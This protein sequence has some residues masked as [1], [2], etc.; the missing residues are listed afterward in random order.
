MSEKIG[1]MEF[2]EAEKTASERD[3]HISEAVKE[4]ISADGEIEISEPCKVIELVRKRPENSHKGTFGKL[5]IIG[6]SERYRGAVQISALAALR[7]G[8]GLVTAI[9]TEGAAQALAVSAKEATV[10]PLP[11]DAK[12]FMTLNDELRD[13]VIEAINSASA[14]LIGPGLGKGSGCVEILKLALKNACCPI[15]L[16]ADGINLVSER[17]EFLRKART[18]PILTPHPAELSRLCGRPLDEILRDR[19]RFAKELAEK[20]RCTVVSKSA[21]TLIFSGDEAC[22]S[23]SGNN[24][25]AKG[26]SGDFL[27]GLIASF[28]AQGYRSFDAARLG[29]TVQGL[30]CEEISEKMSRS[31]ALASDLIGCLPMLFKKIEGRI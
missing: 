28:A 16:D 13:D 22:L 31:A 14:V 25:L 27:A 29:V 24:T 15:I 1:L 6:G 11:H 9:T 30:V 26:G 8:V 12:G 7:S 4:Y 18:E 3:L 19:A 21:G 10:I 17:I 2:S 20:Y 5:V 23:V